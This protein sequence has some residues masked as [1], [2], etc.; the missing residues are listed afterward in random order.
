MKKK[1]IN[2]KKNLKSSLNVKIINITSVNSKLKN[3]IRVLIHFEKIRQKMKLDLELNNNYYHKLYLINYDWFNKY[4]ELNNIKEIYNY[5]LDNKI[6][7]NIIN[8][9]PLIEMDEIIDQVL[10]KISQSMINKINKNNYYEVLKKENLFQLKLSKIRNS[11]NNTFTFYSNCIILEENSIQFFDK[12]F[13]LNFIKN[14]FSIILG[15]NK[16]FIKIDTL[17]ENILE[18]GYMNEKNIFIPEILFDYIDKE[19]LN[20]SISSLMQNRY[21]QYRED[22]VKNKND[23]IYII[24]ES[25]NIIENEYKFESKDQIETKKKHLIKE[26]LN[27][28]IKYYFLNYKFD[29]NSNEII[30]NKFYLINE[31]FMNNYMLFFDYNILETELNKINLVK[32]IKDELNN[33]YNKNISE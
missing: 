5:I 21:S 25:T 14:N 4:L 6:I 29:F 22:F 32:Q 27:I 2:D 26:D 19:D 3:I 24:N 31:A 16:I 7:N 33:D 23:S 1:T 28:L 13:G 20:S 30:E 12:E 9:N 11:E 18:V 17:E 15:D 8:Y 10:S